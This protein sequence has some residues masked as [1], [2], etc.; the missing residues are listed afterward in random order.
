M[1]EVIDGLVAT[2]AEE[3]SQSMG[4]CIPAPELVKVAGVMVATETVRSGLDLL[5]PSASTAMSFSTTGLTLAIIQKKLRDMSK[6]IDVLLDVGR[7]S[8][9]DK[10]AEALTS[11][12]NENFPD[13]YV[14]FEKAADKATDGFHTSQDN[15]SRVSC[16]KIKLF[17]VLMMKCY[18]KS[19]AHFL[20]FDKQTRM[21]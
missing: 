6:K 5:I 2:I 16:A 4:L 19:K 18:D 10:L 20:P 7:K 17:C 21:P 1:G 9:K 3:L 14:A 11:L 13:A 8:A 15:E 12:E